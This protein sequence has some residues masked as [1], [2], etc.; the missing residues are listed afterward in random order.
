MTVYG[1]DK[2]KYI[3]E[4]NLQSVTTFIKRSGHLPSK[5][6]LKEGRTVGIFVDIYG[7]DRGIFEFVILG[8]KLKNECIRR[9]KISTRAK[10][11]PGH[12]ETTCTN[13]KYKYLIS[14]VMHYI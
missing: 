14:S 4:R 8:L 7:N 10:G 12:K 5:N 2:K 9:G 6:F 13:R 1:T 11:K 3:T